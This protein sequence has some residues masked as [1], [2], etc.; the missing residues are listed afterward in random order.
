MAPR[1]FTDPGAVDVEAELQ[2]SLHAALQFERN[3]L[4][5]KDRDGQRE[6]RKLMDP[7]RCRDV[8]KEPAE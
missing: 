2:R 8:A 7:T 1:A 4:Q 6:E 5:E 3:D